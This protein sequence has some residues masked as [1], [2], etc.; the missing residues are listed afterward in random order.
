MTFEVLAMASSGSD[1]VGTLRAATD[2]NALV[3]LWDDAGTNIATPAVDLTKQ[4]V[5]SITIPDDACPPKLDGFDRRGTTLKPRFVDGAEAACDKPLIPRTFVAALDWVSPGPSFRLFLPGQSTYRFDDTY[6]TVTHPFSTAPIESPEAVEPS[7]TVPDPTD[8]QGPP[9]SATD[10]SGPDWEGFVA[11]SWTDLS[12]CLIR[13]DVLMDIS[14][15][16][17]CGYDEA[18]ALSM[19]GT[20]GERYAGSEEVVK[21]VRDPKGVFG[22]PAA[23]AAFDAKAKLPESA[24]DT[25]YRRDGIELHVDPADPNAVWL[26][27]PD[28]HVELWPRADR[29]LCA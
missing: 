6:L 17:H 15:P 19:A 27:Y 14:G 2:Q 29:P 7:T 18:D 8:C 25:G 5:V 13:Y 10:R 20:L 11:R 12:G 16:E 24:V 21:Y 22:L 26:S 4:V 1:P 23:T 28:G 9:G 3:S